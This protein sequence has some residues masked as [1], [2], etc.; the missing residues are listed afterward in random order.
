[1]VSGC[2]IESTTAPFYA[3]GNRVG[4]YSLQES[5]V[6]VLACTRYGLPEVPSEVMAVL[7]GMLDARPEARPHSEDVLDMWPALWG[8]ARDRGRP[9]QP[10]PANQGRKAPWRNLSTRQ[11]E[12]ASK[13]E[14]CCL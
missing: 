2:I 9:V 13:R 7:E 1:M 5:A 14:V 10:T 6:G 4:L 8:I 11:E 3:T 12:R